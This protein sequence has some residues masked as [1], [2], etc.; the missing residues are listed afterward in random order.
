MRRRSMKCTWKGALLGLTVSLA[1]LGMGV[2]VYAKESLDNSLTLMS[3]TV[4]SSGKCGENL[5]WSLDD[6]G[7][8]T[9]SGTGSMW[10]LTLGAGDGVTTHDCPWE[11]DKDKITKVV[12]TENVTSVGNWAFYYCENLESVILSDNIDTL[13]DGCFMQCT[14]LKNVKLTENIESIGYGAFSYCTSLSEVVIPASL[15][16]LEGDIWWGCTSL[17]SVTIEAL[18]DAEYLNSSGLFQDCNSLETFG[19]SE[20]NTVFKSVDGVLFTKDGTVLLQY[21]NGKKDKQYDIPEGTESIG[22]ALKGCIYLEQINIPASLKQVSIGYMPAL[23]ELVIPETVESL[24][25][26]IGPDCDSLTR[27]VNQSNSTASL[28]SH[29]GKVWVDEQGEVVETLAEKTTIV[30]CNVL[31]NIETAKNVETLN[32]QVGESQTLIFTPCY[33]IDTIEGQVEDVVFSTSDS[34]IVSVDEKGVIMAHKLGTATITLSPRFMTR[35]WAGNT[36]TYTVEVKEAADI[37]QITEDNVFFEVMEDGNAKLVN[38]EYCAAD[39]TIP[40]QLSVGGRNIEVTTIGREAFYAN[41]KLQRLV[42]PDTLT[43]IEDGYMEGFGAYSPFWCCVNLK[44]VVFSKELKYIG[45]YA[46]YGCSALENVQL[47]LKLESIREGAFCGCKSITEIQIPESVDE[48]GQ[49]A[50]TNT[51][52]KNFY[53]PATVE[54]CDKLALMSISTLESITVEEGNPKYAS[55]DGVMYTADFRSLIRYPGGKKDEVFVMDER[56]VDTGGLTLPFSEN[57]YLKK[58]VFSSNFTTGEN[59]LAEAM[60]MYTVI[61]EFAVAEGNESFSVKD[62]VLYSKDGKI[63]YLYPPG[64]KDKIFF[65]PSGVEQLGNGCCYPME[66]TIYLEEVYVPASMT[67]FDATLRQGSSLRKVIFA[68][69]SQI[70]KIGEACF[71]G[72]RSLESICLPASIETFSEA[73]GYGN[74][75]MVCS[76]LKFLYVAQG[77]SIY[78]KG[79]YGDQTLSQTCDEMQVYGWGS[80]NTISRLAETFGKNYVDVSSGFDKVLGVTFEDVYMHLE[81]GDSKTLNTVVYPENTTAKT[82]TYESSDQ[83]VVT[84]SADGTVTAVA[85]GVCYITATAT[86]GSGEYARCQICVGDESQVRPGSIDDDLN[87]TENTDNGWRE[88]NGVNYWYENGVKQGYDPDNAA[89]RGKEIYDEESDAWYWLDSKLGGAVAKDMDV[90]QESLAGVWGDVIGEDGQNYG[91][92]VRYDENGHMVKGWQ[93]TEVGTYYFDE[94]FGTMAKGYATI[95]G[96]EYYFDETS[97]VL[98][99]EIGEV[100]EQGWKEADGMEYWYEGYNRQGFHVNDAFRGKEIYDAGSDAWYWLDNVQDGAKAVSK[101]VYQESLAGECGDILGEDGLRYGKWVRYDENG[102]MVKGWDT[103]ENGTY[104]FDRFYGTMLKGKQV[105]DGVE[106]YFDVNTGILQQ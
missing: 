57:Q 32:L 10:D 86:D 70:K 69:K 87:D 5:T 34:D 45:W 58:V 59:A 56:T 78:T 28:V 26:Q 53:L 102:H 67:G 24:G 74:E 3:D 39:Y 38:G 48:I 91:K 8:L 9:I 80:E 50:F 77:A 101:D 104:Y 52:L 11:N 90:Y 81:K 84:V 6:N 97:G 43:V 65:I 31:E 44:E 20:D 51:S 105:I 79:T 23:K 35:D 63:L 41:D 27:I 82:V 61:E 100:P 54:N 83:S 95:D 19:V 14:A 64:K 1:A 22:A 47:P 18:I 99:K 71:K 96:K 42:M 94:T 88:E 7:V 25:G 21:P 46:F 40:S 60:L 62:G 4:I 66:F 13:G 17:K 85:D 12:F 29:Y 2:S 92:W 75:F 36:A 93:E 73:G 89:Y 33:V 72:C 15:T 37:T 76:N 30:M 68:S 49:G 16:S 103:N 98:Q 106:Y 55:K